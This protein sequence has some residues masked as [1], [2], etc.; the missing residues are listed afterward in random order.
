M[1]KHL[2]LPILAFV[3]L[4]SCGRVI[5]SDETSNESLSCFKEDLSESINDETNG[6]PKEELKQ[7]FGMDIPA[8][9]AES[10]EINNQID[11]I[12]SYYIYAKYS[13]EEQL[14][15]YYDLLRQNWEVEYDANY[16]YY[17]AVYDLGNYT[18]YALSFYK[19][20]DYVVIQIYSIYLKGVWPTDLIKEAF[21]EDS[22]VPQYVLDE[23]YVENDLEYYGCVSISFLS[24]NETSEFAKYQEILLNNSW[25]V[26]KVFDEDDES[27]SYY[28][29][30]E[31]FTIGIMYYIYEDDFGDKYFYIDIY[32]YDVD[33]FGQFE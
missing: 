23:Y 12:G 25:K 1:K 24:E 5:N 29:V 10:Y 19:D 32:A 3:C 31:Y 11:E 2:F 28:A 4:T 33:L 8:I 21:G 30:N 6:W 14:K 13:N 7:L 15:N 9:V 18:G 26:K 22:S 20:D 16:D 17:E 27:V